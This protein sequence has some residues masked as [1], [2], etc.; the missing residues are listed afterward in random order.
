MKAHVTTDI[1]KIEPLE[2]T[3]SSF[4]WTV[5]ILFRVESP[6]PDRPLNLITL[7]IGNFANVCKQY[8]IF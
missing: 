2:F 7:S 6:K 4:I 8:I 1:F 3:P 5:K